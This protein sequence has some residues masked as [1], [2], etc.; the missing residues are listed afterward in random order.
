MFRTILVLAVTLALVAAPA[1]AQPYHGFL[2][3]KGVDCFG[4]ATVRGPL[5][6]HGNLDASTSS[7]T[8]ATM[9]VTGTASLPT[10]SVNSGDIEDGTIVNADVG[11]AAALA[12]SK[13]APLTA[14]QVLLGN[15]SNVPTGTAM[16]GDVTID[17]TGTT[18]IGADKVNSAKVLD[19]TLVNADVAAAAAIAHSK[20]ANLTAGQLLL[21]N[22]SNVPTGTAMI[23]D[24]TID[25]TGTTAIGAGKVTAAM[26][27]SGAYGSSANTPAE[28]DDARFPTSAEKSWL[29][30]NTGTDRTVTNV[31]RGVL[32]GTRYGSATWTSGQAECAITF[33][34][35]MGAADYHPIFSVSAAGPSDLTATATVK[36]GSKT[37]NGFTLQVP[38]GSEPTANVTPTYQVL[39]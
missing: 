7:M 12:H 37:V 2:T 23:G 18:T 11:A 3:P 1:I 34:V 6:S 15:G 8:V 20:L 22:S 39:P 31:Q 4:A 36:Y 24:V 26:I 28:G 35:P 25:P 19:G 29:S 10:G 14:G 27:N 5:R 33:D 30:T 16:I 17:P 21:G 38:V 32:D 13:L 9:T